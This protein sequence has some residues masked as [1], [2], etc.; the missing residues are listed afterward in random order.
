M[1]LPTNHTLKEVTIHCH[2]ASCGASPIAGV[3][4]FPFVGRIIKCG[5]VAEAAFITDMSVA[6]AIIPNVAGGTAPGSGT[7]VTGSPF[8]VTAAN[9]AAGTTGSMIPSGASAYGNEDDTI[10]FTPS[11][12]TGTNVPATFFATIMRA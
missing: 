5:M 1:P 3:A 11:G 7:A 2:T 9:S 4:R 10:L 8:T 6:V 12:S